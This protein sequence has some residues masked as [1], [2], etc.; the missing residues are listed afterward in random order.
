MKTFF[1]VLFFGIFATFAVALISC[2]EIEHFSLTAIDGKDGKDGK[3]GADGKD[4][5]TPVLTTEKE[6]ISDLCWIR[7]IFQNGVFFYE[8]TICNGA[9][10]ENG[11]DFKL[12][13]LVFTYEKIELD[14]LCDIIIVYLNGDPFFTFENCDG[15]PGEDGENGEDGNDA[16]PYEPVWNVENQELT[17]LCK[18]RILYVDG[19]EIFRDTI[20]NGQDGEGSGDIYIDLPDYREEF[21]NPEGTDYY[22]NKGCELSYGVLIDQEGSSSG[23]G[24]LYLEEIELGSGWFRSPVFPE[25]GL[26]AIEIG[27]GSSE[28]WKMEVYAQRSNGEWIFI[29]EK[30]IGGNPHFIWDNQSTWDEPFTYYLSSLEDMEYQD[31]VRIEVNFWKVQDE[32]QDEKKGVKCEIDK[33]PSFNM[34]YL[35]A[36]RVIKAIQN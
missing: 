32:N 15:T 19:V 35:H 29:G 13:D 7:T 2:E 17:D 23:N 8:D 11:K 16:P 34:G 14:D 5:T 18:I 10:G 1:K 27:V 21:D 25:S 22:L 6:Q 24:T 20:C 31:F 30:M 9:P 36:A 3:D 26:T 12:N 28:L 33:N 4:G